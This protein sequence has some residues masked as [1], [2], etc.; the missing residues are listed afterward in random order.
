MKDWVRERIEAQRRVID[1]LSKELYEARNK[2]D[3]SKG[4]VWEAAILGFLV[5][6]WLTVVVNLA[7]K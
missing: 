5:G 6:A 1:R 2:Q 3:H 4:D 7:L